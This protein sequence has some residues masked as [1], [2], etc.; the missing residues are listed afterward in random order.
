MSNYWLDQC[1]EL[2]TND[3]D[4]VIAYSE[5]DAKEICHRELDYAWDDMDDW[6][7][8]TMDEMANFTYHENGASTTHPVGYYIAAFGHGYFCC[9]EF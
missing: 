3:M 8:H 4:F 1:L 2:W 5:Q 6:D 9:S 7:W